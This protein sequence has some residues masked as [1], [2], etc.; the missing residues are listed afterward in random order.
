[1]R[2]A[3]KTLHSG[4]S[5]GNSRESLLGRKKAFNPQGI[6]APKGRHFLETPEGRKGFGQEISVDD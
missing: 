4:A 5:R 6:A 2:R 3:K 1:V